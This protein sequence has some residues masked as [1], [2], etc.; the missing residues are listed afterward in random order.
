MG[1]TLSEGFGFHLLQFKGQSVEYWTKNQV[2]GLSGAYFSQRICIFT[3]TACFAEWD[4]KCSVF[5]M[6]KS[7]L[8]L[9]FYFWWLNTETGNDPRHS[10]H[11]SL[12][13]ESS[14]QE[15]ERPKQP[16]DSEQLIGRLIEAG[17]LCGEKNK[18]GK[19]WNSCVSVQ[20]YNPR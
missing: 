13:L 4:N 16:F 2:S 12:S 17:S 5:C 1:R 20:I 15:D 6:R 8:L 18:A 9:L 7:P 11:D 14:F 3:A 19:K 10:F